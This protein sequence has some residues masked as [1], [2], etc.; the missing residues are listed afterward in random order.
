M[1]RK[2]RTSALRRILAGLVC[3]AA[4]A[5]GGFFCLLSTRGIRLEAPLPLLST[6]GAAPF[7]EPAP[8]VPAPADTTT[9][10]LGADTDRKPAFSPA[11]RNAAGPAAGNR[12]SGSGGPRNAPARK[13]APADLSAYRP[14]ARSDGGESCLPR[15]KSLSAKQLKEH[16]TQHTVSDDD[17]KGFL[18][19]LVRGT[20]RAL[21]SLDDATLDASRR[22]LGSI[23]RPDE[24]K[25]RPYGDGARL[26]IG[27]PADTV[28]LGRK[29]RKNSA[30]L[31]KK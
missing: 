17:G 20:R 18:G 29:G 30:P 31:P 9:P 11:A 25:I 5:A 2:N 15:D 12:P 8:S 28:N 26:H 16:L 21:K 23:A 22:A 7:P 14:Q 24:A 6:P 1:R 4:L 27:I 10:P 3:A 13:S 19:D